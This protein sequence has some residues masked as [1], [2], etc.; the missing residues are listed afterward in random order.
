MIITFKCINSFI[1][2]VSFT[3]AFFFLLLKH[4]HTRAEPGS[5]LKESNS[6]T[7]YNSTALN[8][9]YFDFTML[10]C[11]Q[12]GQK[13]AHDEKRKIHS[14]ANIT[15]SQALSAFI[16]LFT[17]LSHTAKT[18]RQTLLLLHPRSFSYMYV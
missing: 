18:S 15:R 17:M 6:Q 5:I 16:S 12:V 3:S 8:Y 2:F 13:F 4:A 11:T 7:F 10:R 14:I 9:K 1:C